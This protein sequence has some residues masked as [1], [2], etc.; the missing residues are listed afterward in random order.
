MP[1]SRLSSQPPRAA[2]AWRGGFVI[3]KAEYTAC[4]AAENGLVV[5]GSS[6]IYR[7]APGAT[8]FESRETTEGFGDAVAVAV[9]PR[10]ARRPGQPQRWAF[11]TIDGL[12]IYDGRGIASL[13]F[14]A[15]HGEPVQLLWAPRLVDADGRQV[16]YVRFDG[17]R[18]LTLLPPGRVEEGPGII[19]EVDGH[20]A[21]ADLLASNGAG[22]F[23][24]ARADD[25][26]TEILVRVL[27]DLPTQRWLE[28]TLPLE[29]DH[30]A[31]TGLAVAGRA[32]AVSLRNG[33]VYL[34]LDL[35]DQPFERIDALSGQPRLE[36]G[37]PDG[38]TI[39]FDDDKSPALFA[40]VR[41]SDTETHLVRLAPNAP[42]LRIAEIEREANDPL[43]SLP[44]ISSL[45]WDAT[46]RTV[47]AAAGHAGILCSTAPGSPSPVGEGAAAKA[48]S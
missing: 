36:Q 17:G 34:T 29:W 47:W 6:C 44:L 25:T 18:L 1:R 30:S 8:R 35:K 4:I 23:A 11:A 21:E 9:E 28:Q 7:L 48:T 19:E 12:H 43:E 2:D 46:R 24:Y 15:D 31:I 3:D 38:G 5:G 22:A 39:V 37:E 26:Y 40:A 45:V 41:R 10:A 13:R 16:L 20:V 42:A 32:V 27:L 33:G 14:P